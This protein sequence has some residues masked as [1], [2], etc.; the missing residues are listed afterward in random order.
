[1]PG[2]FPYTFLPLVDAIL[3][4]RSYQHAPINKP[5]HQASNPYLTYRNSNRT[6]YCACFTPPVH[7]QSS[8]VCLLTGRLEELLTTI[9]CFIL[10]IVE[11]IHI[12]F[13][14]ANL[15]A[16][17]VNRKGH[18][19]RPINGAKTSRTTHPTMLGSRFG[20]IRR[21]LRTSH[22]RMRGNGPLPGHG[23]VP[24]QRVELQGDVRFISVFL[25]TSSPSRIRLLNLLRGTTVCRLVPQRLCS[26]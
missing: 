13:T 18:Q 12:M 8:R 5:L 9:I 24:R 6:T 3:S 21:P 14:P 19:K 7:T 25:P 22:V 4:T 2:L 10:A 26:R 16:T 20:S 17:E 23:A 1:M 15:Y 11:S